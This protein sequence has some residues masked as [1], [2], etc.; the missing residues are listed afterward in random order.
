[1]EDVKERW[2]VQVEGIVQGVGFRPFVHRL[3]QELE[4]AGFVCN[5]GGGVLVEVEGTAIVLQVFVRRIREEAPAM[6]LV[7]RV[8]CCSIRATGQRGFAIRRSV[9]GEPAGMVSRGRGQ[10]HPHLAGFRRAPAR[11][12]AGA[13]ARVTR[14]TRRQ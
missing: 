13:R 11:L 6:S 9:A 2:Q 4:L 3:A 10:R 12:R 7:E 14:A 8:E 5:T 1:M